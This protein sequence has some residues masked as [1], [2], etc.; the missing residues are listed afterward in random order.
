[1]TRVAS[2]LG[3]VRFDASATTAEGVPYL[4]YDTGSGIMGMIMPHILIVGSPSDQP[5]A[6]SRVLLVRSKLCVATDTRTPK[7]FSKGQKLT[8]TL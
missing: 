5:V 3:G 7:G 6:C 8:G 1:M 4:R 2:V